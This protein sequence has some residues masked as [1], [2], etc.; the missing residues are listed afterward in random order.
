MET[1]KKITIVIGA[2]P[3]PKRY[4]YMAVIKLIEAGY[5]VYPIGIKDGNINGISIIKNKLEVNNVHTITMYLSPKHQ[6]EYYD[7]IVKLNPKRLIFNPGTYNQELKTIAEG[8]G[9]EIIY[10]CTLVMINMGLY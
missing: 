1:N 2:S 10:D 4:S 3:N 8:N 7:Y 5:I 9:I 6:P